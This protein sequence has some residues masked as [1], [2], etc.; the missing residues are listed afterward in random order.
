M[1]I[2][3]DDLSFELKRMAR[4]VA[5]AREYL[6]FD[7]LRTQIEQLEAKSGE[8]GFWNDTAG[9]QNHMRELNR[10]KGLLNPWLAI[11][12]DVGDAL[13]LAEMA[14]EDPAMQAELVQTATELFA[15]LDSLETRA[16]LCDP[17]DALAC[18][19]HVH[20]GAGGTESCD[21]AEM[22]LRMYTR[23]FERTGLSAETI[24]ITPGDE[25]G[26]RSATLLVSGDYAHGLLK[27]ES[28]VHRLV[29]ISPF[30]A[31]SR[32]HTSFCS[33]YAWPQVE[34]SI[35]VEIR[36]EDLKIDTYRASGAGGQHVNKT[37][38]AVRMTHLP[39][40]IVVQCQ[41]ERSQHQNRAVALKM[42]RSR[43]FQVELD[44]RQAE[45]AA[46]ESQKKDISWGNQIRS[47]VFQPYQMVKDHRTGHETGNIPA[48]MD[49]DLDKFIEAYLR[50]SAGMPGITDKAAP[51]GKE[52]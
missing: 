10:V 19:F 2:Q 33:I 52:A 11:E 21:W 4:R 32:R 44:E 47:Y 3:P 36:D 8:P 23:W 46:K 9:A 38:S 48:V 6:H 28:G 35:E 40:K 34:D 43:L 50:W 24:E 20:A 5:E 12:G 16:L 1:A 39:T 41:N 30:D 14:D 51:T 13:E 25:A 42:L 29:R 17:S 27:A 22:L 45:Q 18:Y 26:I 15:R 31:N 37:D 49:G 7:Q